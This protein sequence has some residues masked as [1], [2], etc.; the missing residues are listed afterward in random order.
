MWQVSPPPPTHISHPTSLHQG[1]LTP[2]LPPPGGGH[3]S[4]YSIQS[5]FNLDFSFL[6]G[7]NQVLFWQLLALLA[8][9]NH[10]YTP[11]ARA[12]CQQ[13]KQ[14]F[15]I[16]CTIS[17]SKLLCDRVWLVL[18]SIVSSYYCNWTVVLAEGNFYLLQLQTDLKPNAVWGTKGLLDI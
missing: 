10:R 17:E 11:L 15:W 6:C 5:W 16:G 14:C 9:N 7:T 18:V 2:H 12:K 3:I 13:C 4:Q 1:A 8:E